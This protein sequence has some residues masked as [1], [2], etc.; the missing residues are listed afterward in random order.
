M[1][2]CIVHG[3]HVWVTISNLKTDVFSMGTNV[4]YE[5][6]VERQISQR[7]ECGQ[8]KKIVSYWTT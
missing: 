5:K 6:R 7:C 3:T 1:T 8:E 2:S 4:P